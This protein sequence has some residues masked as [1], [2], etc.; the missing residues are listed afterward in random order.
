M[1]AFLQSG[2]FPLN[3]K[4]WSWTAS[5]KGR[6]LRCERTRKLSWRRGRGSWSVRASHSG[7]TDPRLVQL[8]GTDRTGTSGDHERLLWEALERDVSEAETVGKLPQPL[9]TELL[10]KIREFVE[11]VAQRQSVHDL[12]SADFALKDEAL[13]PD[14]QWQLVEPNEPSDAVRST[15]PRRASSFGPAADCLTQSPRDRLASQPGGAD[16]NQNGQERLAGINT[17]GV[18]SP[19]KRSVCP[20]TAVHR[21]STVSV[22][23]EEWTWSDDSAYDPVDGANENRPEQQL[24]SDTPNPIRG[25]AKDPSERDIKA[26]ESAH[27]ATED[28]EI[29]SELSEV[30]HA[31]DDR[32]LDTRDAYGRMQQRLRPASRTQMRMD[33][34]GND[35]Q[36][37]REDARIG[38]E[39]P[40][41]QASMRPGKRYRRRTG[42]GTRVGIATPEPE[43]PPASRALPERLAKDAH[44][45]ATDEEVF[46]LARMYY[47][48]FRGML[49]LALREV[50]E[51]NAERWNRRERLTSRLRSTLEGAIA[52]LGEA[53]TERL[54]TTNDMNDLLSCL[55]G[56]RFL[57]EL[58]EVLELME[59]RNIPRDN[60]TYTLVL[61]AL[62]KAKRIDTAIDIFENYVVRGAAQDGAPC[63]GRHQRSSRV[64][65][66]L[67]MYNIL[68][69]GCA[70]TL[71]LDK[72][73]EFFERLQSPPDNFS[74]DTHTYCALLDACARCSNTELALHVFEEIERKGEQIDSA[75]YGALLAAVARSGDRRLAFA[76]RG[77][78]RRRG[79]APTTAV[80]AN[81]MELCAADGDYLSGFALLREMRAWGRDPTHPIYV[82][83]MN[84]CGRSGQPEY[85]MAVLDLMKS[86][87]VAPSESAYCALIDAWAR[88]KRLDRAFGVWRDMRAGGFE[89]R[90][91]TA[92]ALLSACRRCKNLQVAH[93][94]YQALRAELARERRTTETSEDGTNSL[95]SQQ[96]QIFR[97]MMELACDVGDYRHAVLI[98]LTDAAQS[99]LLE[100]KHARLA[101]RSSLRRLRQAVFRCS[102]NGDDM[103]TLR[104]AFRNLV[105]ARAAQI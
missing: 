58:E 45:S 38:P 52:L 14:S 65:P 96:V 100:S 28:R 70:R 63:G 24:N 47:A 5:P 103:E 80:F 84:A 17:S 6:P 55:A 46:R 9:R 29:L 3:G 4:L 49:S 61:D 86:N 16:F 93:W 64:H 59:S 89:P 54:V 10:S 51:C 7:E 75:V 87:G 30:E 104:N 60:R 41:S 57:D 78:M 22:H 40:V 15:Q 99:G 66:T 72:A 19:E 77:L 43:Q 42:N 79:L 76:V 82:N 11:E 88:I 2:A 73:F 23:A 62:C 94:L 12:K 20:P 25:S 101:L 71:R 67:V 27:H 83:L 105:D 1:V 95:A 85:A 102:A 33:V 74:P 18:D 90:L 8:G 39:Q 32:T 48:Q 56:L 26:Q 36:R 13:A 92:S 37:A 91:R 50:S 68:I 31:N 21:R 53:G 69:G 97:T 81:L 35:T 44:D 34:P 98:Y